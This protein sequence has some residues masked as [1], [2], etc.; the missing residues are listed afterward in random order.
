MNDGKGGLN[1]EDL[2]LDPETLAEQANLDRIY[3]RM[4]ADTG[5]PIQAQNTDP[6]LPGYVQMIGVLKPEMPRPIR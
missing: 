5:A 1:P 6:D 2:V 3:K 4:E